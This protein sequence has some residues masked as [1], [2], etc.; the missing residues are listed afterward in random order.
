MVDLAF[1][2]CCLSLLGTIGGCDK[3]TSSTVISEV[4]ALLRLAAA[5]AVE[6]VCS[7][8]TPFLLFADLVNSQPIEEAE[9][10]FHFLEETIKALKDVR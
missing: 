5:A 10:N 2:E 1:R 4:Q 9:V 3:K 8:S 6:C 7:A